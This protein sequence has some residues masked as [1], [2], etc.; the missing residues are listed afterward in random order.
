LVT[1]R[2]NLVEDHAALVADIQRQI[3]QSV[4]VLL[5]IDTL[6]RSLAGSE[7]KDEDMASYIRAADAIRERFDCAIVV[8]HHCGVDGTRPRGHTSLTGATDAQLAVVRENGN[9]V[10]TVEWMKDGPEGDQIV[11]RLEQVDLGTDTEGDSLCSCVIVPVL[12]DSCV[13]QQ[14]RERK[15]KGAKK[16]VLDLLRKAIDEAGSVLPESN[17]SRT[18]GQFQSRPGAPTPTRERLP[19]A[20][21]RTPDRRHLSG[22]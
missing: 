20:T 16:V 21:S 4:P 14:T 18:P 6:N 1:D 8:V 5:V 3:G 2:T 11:S 22:Q 12:D 13:K 15:I 17:H 10:V 9:I 19:K 7:S